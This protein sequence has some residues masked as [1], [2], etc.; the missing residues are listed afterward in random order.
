MVCEEETVT[1]D[2][3][4]KKSNRLAHYLQKRGVE[5]ETLVGLLLLMNICQGQILLLDE[6]NLTIIIRNIKEIAL[7]DYYEGQTLNN[8][9][10]CLQ[11]SMQVIFDSGCNLLAGSC[12]TL[13]LRY[14]CR[15]S[16]LNFSIAYLSIVLGIF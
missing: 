13:L 14:L 7:L 5:Q 8:Y 6:T 4:N 16:L 3:L 1:N 9:Q 12:H 10:G 11:A 2:E 15:S